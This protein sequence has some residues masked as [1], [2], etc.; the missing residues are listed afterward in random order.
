[1]RL[2]AKRLEK[3]KD[4]LLKLRLNLVRM[5]MS[6]VKILGETEFAP[7][8]KNDDGYWIRSVSTNG[9]VRLYTSN[10]I[11]WSTVSLNSMGIHVLVSLM[12]A[13]YYH[14]YKLIA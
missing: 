10:E 3:T 8:V 12:D 13:I 7:P 14:R 6:E 2:T 5:I 1:M 9:Y 4:D 11:L